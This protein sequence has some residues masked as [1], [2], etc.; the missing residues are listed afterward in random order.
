MNRIE[1][2]LGWVVITHSL[3]V[4]LVLL[5]LLILT[6]FMM[7]LGSVDGQY[8]ILKG[9]LYSVL[10]IPVF[11][12][13]LLPIALLIGTLIGLGALAN[14]SELTILRA[15]GWSIMRI[16]GA[17]IKTVLFFWLL[18]AFVGEWLGPPS[19]AYAN[20]LKA[21][22]LEKNISL[23]QGKGAGF[24]F[25]DSERFINV[26]QVVSAHQMRGVTIYTMREG[27]LKKVEYAELADY[28][29]GR[30]LFSELETQ[31]LN[32]QERQVETMNQKWLDWQV[33]KSQIPL[34]RSLPIDADMIDLLQVEPRFLRIDELYNY[35]QFLNENQLES[36]VYRLEFWR[37]LA[38]PFALVGMIALVFPLIFGSQRQ[39]SMGQRMF[40]G[41]LIGMGFHLLNQLV[42]NLSVVY[43]IP[44]AVGAFMPSLL[45]IA[46]AL[47]L[48]SRLK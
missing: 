15:T 13:Q 6:E 39:A 24:W 7:Q 22:A 28:Y 3:L 18:M 31:T 41:I 38:A 1:R 25:R 42:G 36:S 30:W 5:T 8:T 20:K 9:L 11:G 29:Q 19:E 40:V 27:Q 37:K 32:W 23:G 34:E 35:M 26:K 45:L 2:Y 33:A 16:F 43:Q 21:E 44:V 17:V 46:L 48:F 47:V 14:H 4:M 10:K 12:Y